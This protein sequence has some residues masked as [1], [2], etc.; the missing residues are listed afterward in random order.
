M[1][2]NREVA[3]KVS[4]LSVTYQTSRGPAPVVHDVSFSLARGETLAIVGESG[5]GKSTMAMATAG[6]LPDQAHVT[7]TVALDG[8]DIVGQSKR[9][10]EDIR[11]SAVAVI[12]QN[13][14]TSLNPTMRVGDQIAEQL[15]RHKAMKRAVARNRSLELLRE[16]MINDPEGVYRKYPHQL[17][18]GMKQR[19]MIAMAVSCEP[20]VLIADEPTTALDVTVQAEILQIMRALSREHS[21]GLLLVTHDMGVVAE[22]AT[23][24]AVVY[25]GR[26]VE[27]APAA[28]L[29]TDPLHPYTQGLLH[30][31]P[32]IDDPEARHRRLATIPRP[33]PMLEHLEHGYEV[34]SEEQEKTLRPGHNPDSRFVRLNDN[35]SPVVREGSTV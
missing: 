6:L 14:M 1:T 8:V 31:Q 29:F 11:G 18:G 20:K 7:G 28:D 33:A 24:V 19:V 4:N 5:S 22:M 23:H 9:V 10:L 30:S 26:F 27:Y 17:S 2:L 35:F 21:M 16:V 3:L 12:F 25:D 13:P 15:I 34:R 32:R